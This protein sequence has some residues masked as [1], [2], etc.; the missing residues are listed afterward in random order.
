MLF[1]EILYRSAVFCQ[2]RFFCEQPRKK[3]K[4]NR[5]FLFYWFYLLFATNVAAKIRKRKKVRTM[6]TTAFLVVIII[7]LLSLTA[8]DWY[9]LIILSYL[10]FCIWVRIFFL[11]K[12]LYGCILRKKLFPNFWWIPPGWHQSDI[13][14]ATLTVVNACSNTFLYYFLFWYVFY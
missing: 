4:T 6:S 8:N 12:M 3:P 7:G 1:L 11:I 13:L 2:S 10:A 5:H 14:I 9:I